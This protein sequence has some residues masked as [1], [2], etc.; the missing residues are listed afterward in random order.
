MKIFWK[1]IIVLCIIYVIVGCCTLKANIYIN[2]CM[3]L[4]L[5]SLV[6][7][8]NKSYIYMVKNKLIRSKQ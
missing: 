6:I 1:K 3:L 7:Y 2:V 4:L 8:D 5:L